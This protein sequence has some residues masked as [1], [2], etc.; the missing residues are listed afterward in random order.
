MQTIKNFTIVSY[1]DYNYGDMLIKNSFECILKTV[2]QNLKME[3]CAVNRMS[4]KDIDENKIKKSDLICFAGGG[5]L[6]MSYLNFYDY[7]KRI[8]DVAEEND[9]PVI[10]SSVGVNNM[11]YNAEDEY[12]IKELL[13]HN[14][15]KSISVREQKE[16]FE[17]FVNRK[18]IE[19]EQVCDPAMWSKYLIGEKSNAS[20]K[21][22][23]IGINIV[24]RGLFKDNGYV[25]GKREE[26]EYIDNLISI[27]QRNNYDYVLYT[28][29]NL[30]DNKELYE[31]VK[32][33]NIPKNNYLYIETSHNL[34][35]T[36]QDFDFVCALRLHSAIIST[37]FNTPVINIVWNEK[38]K[39]FYDAI[40]HIERAFEEDDVDLEKIEKIIVKEIGKK[41]KEN[42]KYLMSTYLNI[43]KAIKNIC[44][45]TEEIPLLEFDEICKSV[46]S[47]YK[48][49]KN[50]YII[51]DLKFRGNRLQINF[52]AER[53]AYIE[54]KKKI[55]KLE[56]DISKLE[57]KNKKLENELKRIN[58]K[59][60][61]RVYRKIKRLI[62]K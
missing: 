12:K 54:S 57:K 34:L 62:K 7:V 25:W 41:E 13:N 48:K 58:Q 53:E 21:T 51:E 55:G 16:W 60:A 33:R 10:F 2:L 59:P 27:A 15:I 24:R 23:K 50:E 3:N 28:N 22:K 26:Y 49:N 29:G 5:L 4:L 52:F 14:C 8:I 9:I 38:I 39:Y 37:S 56:K 36:V 44:E 35:E 1:F 31:Y 47:F 30:G 6:G 45:I 19:I 20:G 61:V 43:L 40:G 18:D 46:A 32:S 11:D 42:Q 17:Y